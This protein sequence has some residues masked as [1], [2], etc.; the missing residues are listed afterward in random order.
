MV[1]ISPGEFSIRMSNLT[2]GQNSGRARSEPNVSFA[3]ED[4][5]HSDQQFVIFE[6]FEDTYHESLTPYAPPP[7][8]LEDFEK[9]ALSLSSASSPSRRNTI[10]PI[11]RR[12]CSAPQLLMTDAMKNSLPDVLPL[13]LKEMTESQ[14]FDYDYASSVFGDLSSCMSSLG[15]QMEGRRWLRR[16]TGGIMS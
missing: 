1:E 7:S 9:M 10:A 13:T 8:T 2:H 15:E 12:P 3:D 14:T 16:S 5:D 4:S 11:D 6:D